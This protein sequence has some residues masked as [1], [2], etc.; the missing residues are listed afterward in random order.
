MTPLR[1]PSRRP[2]LAL[3]VA[4]VACGPSARRADHA[5]APTV[6]PMEAVTPTSKVPDLVALGLDPKHLPPLGEVPER[7]V[8]P[9]MDTWDDSLDACCEHCHEKRTPKAPTREKRVAAEMWSRF[10]R[11][12]VTLD[13]SPVYCDSC[14]HGA[15]RFLDRSDPAALRAWMRD[16]YVVRLRKRDG[17][18]VECATCHGERLEAKI[19]ERLWGI[20]GG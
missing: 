20:P 6:G 19:I 3:L 11:E 8:K 16:S 10:T 7:A 1:P 18:P 15:L 4:L 12:L 2:A 9:L 14:H 13:G 17:S 5:A